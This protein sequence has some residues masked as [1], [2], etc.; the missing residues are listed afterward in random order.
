M[1]R[2]FRSISILYGMITQLENPAIK[3]GWAKCPLKRSIERKQN[4]EK[5][6]WSNMVKW[7]N[8]GMISK[9]RVQLRIY[10]TSDTFEWQF[11]SKLHE[12]LAECKLKEFW[13]I[14]SGM[15]SKRDTHSLWLRK[16][17]TRARLQCKLRINDKIAPFLANHN[18]DIFSVI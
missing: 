12:A 3:C 7:N 14:S 18:K 13:G 6:S 9:M 17:L 15:H 5:Y 8:G 4:T 2:I 11:L 10:T 1:I 16:L